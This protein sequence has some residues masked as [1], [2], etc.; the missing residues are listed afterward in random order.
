M[1]GVLP[2]SPCPL[3]E[4]AAGWER[5]PG[6]GGPVVITT[7]QAPPEGGS[8]KFI[9]SAPVAL[10]TNW[11]ARNSRA[12]GRPGDRAGPSLPGSDWPRAQAG[13]NPELAPGPPSWPNLSSS[14][15]WSLQCWGVGVGHPGRGQGRLGATVSSPPLIILILNWPCWPR[16]AKGTSCSP[17][18]RRA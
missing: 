17:C 7:P 14:R 18:P 12:P 1:D 4:P 11:M 6:P 10:P 13:A 3:L 16:E 8:L 9:F 2:D 15:A 5:L